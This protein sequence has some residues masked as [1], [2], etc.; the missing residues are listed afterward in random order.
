MDAPWASTPSGSRAPSRY[1]LDDIYEDEGDGQAY[2]TAVF[3]DT[4]AWY[5]IV[6]AVT[7]S[8]GTVY[9]NNETHITSSMTHSLS[10]ASNA[11]RHFW[12]PGDPGEFAFDG[13]GAEVALIDG[14]ALT[15]SSFAE[16]NA[17]TG[18]WVPKD[19]SG[20]TFGSNG[21]YLKFTDNN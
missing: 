9:V 16:T 3:R 7:P 8:G 18:Q 21:H 6:M 12:H 14:Q 2:S 17:I 4:S 10:S 11:I 13:Y 19:L 1:H 15:P 5:H 20:L